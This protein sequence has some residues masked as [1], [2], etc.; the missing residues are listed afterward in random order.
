MVQRKHYVCYGLTKCSWWLLFSAGI[1][2]NSARS[3]LQER[4][5]VV[6]IICG[7]RLGVLSIKERWWKTTCVGTDC[8]MQQNTISF[9]SI[10]DVWMFDKKPTDR[11]LLSYIFMAGCMDMTALL[12]H[13]T[14][15]GQAACCH[16]HT[17]LLFRGITQYSVLTYTQKIKASWVK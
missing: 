11:L 15:A 5:S 13:N 16:K 3:Y 4:Q 17:M 12:E 10:T 6:Q 8:Q 1:A 9:Q 2:K 14:P 7:G